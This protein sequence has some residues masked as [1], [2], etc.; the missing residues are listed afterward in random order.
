MHVGSVLQFPEQN[1]SVA[2][3]TL[4]NAVLTLCKVFILSS[5]EHK[6][7]SKSQYTYNHSTLTINHS[8]ITTWMD[9][10][11]QCTRPANLMSTSSVPDSSSLMHTTTTVLMC[12]LADTSESGQGSL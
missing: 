6:H 3:R 11:H 7:A 10:T 5:L 1:V 9:H 8:Q 4:G 12:M 2:H